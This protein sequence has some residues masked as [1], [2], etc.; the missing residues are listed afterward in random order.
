MGFYK[1]IAE[2]IDYEITSNQ[3]A[4]LKV[5][6]GKIQLPN[7]KWLLFHPR[8]ID[9]VVEA[10]QAFR[11]GL[12]TG[13]S[14]DISTIEKH[15]MKD[16]E[17]AINFLKD[18]ALK[19]YT[20]FTLDIE[21]SNLLTDKARN[22]ILCIGMAWAID[23][24]CCFGRECF[25]N[26]RFLYVFQRFLSSDKFHFIL[27]N[28]IFDKS[29]TKIISGIDIR[30]DDDTM[31]MHYCGINEHKGTH[32]LKDLAQLYLGFPEWDKVLDDYKRQYCREHK[33]LLSEFQFDY[34][35]PDTL[36]EYNCYDV[37]ATFGLWELFSK[38]M[39]E[40]SKPIYRKLI[41][42]SNFYADMIARGMLMDMNYWKVMCKELEDRINDLEDYLYDEMHGASPSSPK[43]LMA[44][45]QDRYPMD[46]IEST[47]KESLEK[48]QER[49]IDDEFLDKLLEHRKMAKYLKTYGYGLYKHKDYQNVIHCEFKLHGTET[50]RLSSANP[51]MQNIPRN[52]LVKKLFIARPGY[53]LIQLDYSQSELRVM[54]YVTGDEG[55]KNVYR[56]GR[57]L[58]GE[59]AKHIFGDKY[60][61]HDKDQRMAA[62]II[63]FGIPYGR[64]PG[65]VARQLK[66]SKYEA[67]RYLDNWFNAAPKVKDYIK[68]CHEMALSDPQKLY[69]TVFGRTRH[70]YITS[71]SVHHA[72]NQSVNFPISSTAN[73]LTIYSLVEIGKWLKEKNFDAYLVNTVHDSIIIEARPEDVKE[74]CIHCQ[75]VMA[76]MPQKLLPNCDLPFRADAEVGTCYGDLEDAD[77]Y[78]DEDDD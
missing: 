14:F 33:I 38:L 13:K 62:K 73:D 77:F 61:P 78:E 11:A 37:C 16:P 6:N 52:S 21:S 51:N 9:S 4:Y 71:D 70:Y 31:L 24:A 57:D 18:L 67:Q 25:A 35:D 66:I 30:I 23:K 58:H 42:A 47:G 60:D 75:K 12:L 45:L 1:E 74:I 22:H 56:E 49:H 69:Y 29:R 34:Y 2:G 68:L 27:H 55:L 19:G 8:S 17:E 3:D 5:V 28:G 50:G 54:A 36:N 20:N 65:G 59:M 43:Q 10:C 39:T 63:N 26:E 64:T 41:E 72:K 48:L 44:F 76:E 32:G 53:T 46:I 15:I 7:P 40:I